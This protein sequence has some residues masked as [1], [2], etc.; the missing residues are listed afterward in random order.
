M[1]SLFLKR[2]NERFKG[3]LSTLVLGAPVLLLKSISM[4][5]TIFFLVFHL[6]KI[7]KL[8]TPNILIWKLCERSS[9]NVWTKLNSFCFPFSS[10]HTHCTFIHTYT[11]YPLILKKIPL[12]LISN[13]DLMKFEF[14]LMEIMNLEI[15]F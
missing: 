7:K 13:Q 8:S 1:E 15:I 14:V 4:F 10:F 9:K 6:L 2:K 11:L 12:R 5:R 3:I